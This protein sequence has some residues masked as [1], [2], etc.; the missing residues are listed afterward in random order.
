MDCR[1]FKMIL[2]REQLSNT[3]SIKNERKEKAQERSKD[4]S[5]FV[6][7]LSKVLARSNSCST[8]LRSPY[9][10]TLTIPTRTEQNAL[11]YRE[12]QWRERIEENVFCNISVRMKTYFRGFPLP[13]TLFS[14]LCFI[15]SSS[16]GFTKTKRDFLFLF[17][18]VI[19]LNENCNRGTVGLCGIS[20]YLC[21]CII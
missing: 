3:D 13:S 10:K 19:P 12:A 21:M 2:G 7:F 14:W 6:F 1:T 4:T 15:Y 8:F 18:P 20:L 17:F 9:I 5:E 16:T 11:K